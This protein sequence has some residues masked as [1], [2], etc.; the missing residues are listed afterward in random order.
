[1][2]GGR[3]WDHSGI[4]RVIWS[5]LPAHRH[6]DHGP[7]PALHA[8]WLIRHLPMLLHCT[9]ALQLTMRGTKRVFNIE[10]SAPSSVR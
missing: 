3:A 6:H 5:N 1:L 8:R 4:M 10:F 2:M 9:T 7:T